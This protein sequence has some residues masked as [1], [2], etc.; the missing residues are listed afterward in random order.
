MTPVQF[1]Q[2]LKLHD[3]DITVWLNSPGGDVFAAVQIYNMLKEHQGKVTVKIDSL[4]ASAASMIAMAGDEVLISPCGM[5][6]IHDPMSMVFGNEA[7]L[8]ACIDMLREVKEAIINAYEL[9]TGA[10][11]TKLAQYM[12]NETWLNAKKAVDLGFCDGLMYENETKAEDTAAGFEFNSRA[13]AYAVVN[14]LKDTKPPEPEGVQADQLMKR[15]EL[16]K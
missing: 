15:L 5:L 11:R 9:K 13:L 1:K 3:G 2:E 4:A 16:I 10:R 8:S 7:D 6:M 12:T 14:K